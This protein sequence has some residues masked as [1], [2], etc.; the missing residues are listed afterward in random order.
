MSTQ[1]DR[2]DPSKAL[3]WSTLKSNGLVLDQAALHIPIEVHR[4]LEKRIRK[5]RSSRR[6]GGED[7][8]KVKKLVTKVWHKAENTVSEIVKSPLFDLSYPELA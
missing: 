8:L 7:Q 1:T 3:Y 5:P 2:L 6:L 4:L